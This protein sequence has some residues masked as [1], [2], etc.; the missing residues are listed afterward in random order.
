MNAPF[1]A[2]DEGWSEDDA[3]EHLERLHARWEQKHQADHQDQPVPKR[4]TDRVLSLGNIVSMI[5]IAGSL[6]ACGTFIITTS[7]LAERK[8]AQ[9][10]QAIQ[11]ADSNRVYLKNLDGRMSRIE[12]NS[13]LQT[14][15]LCS[16]IKGEMT[17]V[18][19]VLKNEM[20][21]NP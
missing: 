20:T 14:L 2:K 16:L 15:A 4:S 5:A 3:I 1:P 12:R 10:S 9:V 13:N 21:V 11:S 7:M 17:G 18:C 6:T 19:S 8:N